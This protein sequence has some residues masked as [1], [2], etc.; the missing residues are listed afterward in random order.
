MSI[1]RNSSNLVTISNLCFLQIPPP[2][3]QQQCFA[4]VIE[5]L[6]ANSRPAIHSGTR[7]LLRA[8][9]RIMPLFSLRMASGPSFLSWSTAYFQARAPRYGPQ[10]NS[11]LLRFFHGSHQD[12]PL[13]IYAAN[14]SFAGVLQIPS[15]E[16]S[17]L[18]N[19]VGE[20]ILYLGDENGISG[21][22]GDDSINCRPYW[23]SMSSPSKI[24]WI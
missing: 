11:P 13:W 2:E 19:T 4:C 14:G 24:R 5:R 21:V 20:F 6:V 18:I 22:I 3:L 23:L 10:S 12:Y 16:Q 17:T 15:Y 1:A 9:R 8:R 7:R